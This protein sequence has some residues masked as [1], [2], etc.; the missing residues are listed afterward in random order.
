MRILFIA[1][2]SAV[3]MMASSQICLAS[4]GLAEWTVYTPGGNIICH[5]DGW[6]E[7]Y[8]DCLRADDSNRS[9]TLEQRQKVYVPHLRRWQYYKDYVIGE[10]DQGVFAFNEINKA[11]QYFKN[12]N[13]LLK[14]VQQNK[15]GRP[16]SDWLT[17]SDGWT[18]AW[19][20]Q[21]VW[22]PCK[23]L[24]QGHAMDE[25]ES[26]WIQSTGMSKEK[27]AEVLSTARM[28]LYR[29]TTWGRQCKQL[30]KSEPGPNEFREFCNEI[31][32]SH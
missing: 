11:V 22:K 1:A 31:L 19:F 29:Q 20:P 23:A 7:T 9:L 10:S 25:A 6:K 16:K 3:F 4:I 13:E 28:E 24:T 17:A 30:R 18:E 21:F 5:S 15:L 26:Q 27:C 32:D 8:G 2:I 14:A 12:E